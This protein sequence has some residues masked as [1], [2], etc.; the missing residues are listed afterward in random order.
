MEVGAIKKPN[1]LLTH[2]EFNILIVQTGED[3]SPSTNDDMAIDF[4]LSSEQ[5]LKDLFQKVQFIKYRMQNGKMDEVM[6][7][8]TLVKQND[9]FYFEVVDPEL[10]KWRFSYAP[11]VLT[12]EMANVPSELEKKST[13]LSPPYLQ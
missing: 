3:H 12:H 10:R 1:I 13:L 9:E 7:Q 2:Q 4:S 11:Q 8:A 6:V 5:E